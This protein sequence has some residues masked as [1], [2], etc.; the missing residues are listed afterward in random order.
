MLRRSFRGGTFGWYRAPIGIGTSIGIV[1]GPAG[2]TV[3]V[4]HRSVPGPHSADP[5]DRQVFRRLLDLVALGLDVTLVTA[6]RLPEGGAPHT[7]AGAGVTLELGPRETVPRRLARLAAARPDAPGPG[8]AH[9]GT[10]GA[11]MVTSLMLPRAHRDAVLAWP[12]PV[13]ID[14]DHLPSTERRLGRVAFRDAEQP[15]IDTE[16][17]DLTAI[18]GALLARADL[19]I[20]NSDATAATVRTATDTAVIV[21]PPSVPD[22]VAPA[23]SS[24]HCAG[25]SSPRVVVPGRFSDE[26]ATP[27]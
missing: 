8:A 20:A 11:L 10:P 3:T 7:L 13:V 26:G 15:G 23:A 25:D 6:E 4:L 16:I 2:S 12:G 21:V 22:S 18:E 24:H 1:P 5:R 9:P 27:D 14:V 19:V 17:A